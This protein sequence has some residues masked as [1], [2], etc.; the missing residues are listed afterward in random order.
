M[1]NTTTA[2]IKLKPVKDEAQEVMDLT[3]NF[4]DSVERIKPD[5]VTLKN[6]H[7]KELRGDSDDKKN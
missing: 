6:C 5:P 4:K 3:E 7:I 1:T 2:F